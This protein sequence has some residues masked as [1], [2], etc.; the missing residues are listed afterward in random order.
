MENKEQ[1]KCCGAKRRTFAGLGKDTCFKCGLTFFP[2]HQPPHQEPVAT[3]SEEKCDGI[4]KDYRGSNPYSSSIKEDIKVE[5]HIC[6]E[7]PIKFYD[8]NDKEIC[9]H[10]ALKD[11][12]NKGLKYHNQDC[13]REYPISKDYRGSNPITQEPMEWA[14][15]W[16]SEWS[17]YIKTIEIGQYNEK[18]VNIGFIQAKELIKHF[19]S[20]QIKRAEERAI[21]RCKKIVNSETPQHFTREYRETDSMR[22]R[23]IKSI[24]TNQ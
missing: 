23:I 12:Y 18:G 1:S 19:I 24:I 10:Q 14:K 21:E 22:D 7:L 11:E 20:S 17:G 3:Q 8:D 2:C 16:E 9:V 13:V 15:E 5:S 6:F 4:C